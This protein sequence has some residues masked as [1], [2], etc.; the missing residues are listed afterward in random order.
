MLDLFLATAKIAPKHIEETTLPLLFSQLPDGAVP[1]TSAA[2]AARALATLRTLCIAPVLFETLV[3]RLLV[4]LELCEDI[5]YALAMLGTL[6]SVL[7]SK[8]DEGHVDVAKYVESLVP[9]LYELV[10]TKG[11]FGDVKLV[12]AAAAVVTLVARTLTAECVARSIMVYWHRRLIN[13]RRR[14]KVLATGV[15]KLY[16][17]GDSSAIG[18]KSTAPPCPFEVCFHSRRPVNSADTAF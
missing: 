13:V 1:A 18:L 12:E 16:L 4:R 3:I 8:I 11:L 14:Q 10:G 2:R 17:H 7:Q 5:W 15:C 9:K 6:Q